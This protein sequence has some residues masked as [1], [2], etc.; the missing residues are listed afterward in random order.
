MKINSSI[1]S[2]VAHTP[3]RQNPGSTSALNTGA[4]SHPDTSV[5]EKTNPVISRGIDRVDLRSLSDQPLG[6]RQFQALAA[7]QQT[8]AM[9]EESNLSGL[10]NQSV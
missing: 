8:Q 9:D 3:S 5:I 7:Y 4:S 1:Q 10:I 2:L 6:Y